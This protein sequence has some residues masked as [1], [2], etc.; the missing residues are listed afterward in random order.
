MKIRYKYDL[1]EYNKHFSS[2]SNQNL[3]KISPHLDPNTFEYDVEESDNTVVVN[4]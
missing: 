4:D 3:Q 2:E 1:S